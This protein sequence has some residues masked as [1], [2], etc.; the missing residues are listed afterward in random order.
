MSI[1]I[2]R[3][4]G[5]NYKSQIEASTGKGRP[6][7]DVAAL[8]SNLAKEF[9]C[10]QGGSPYPGVEINVQLPDSYLRKILNDPEAQ[11]N[12]R[13]EFRAFD[14]MTLIMMQECSSK[15]GVLKYHGIYFD[16]NGIIGMQAFSGSPP[17]ASTVGNSKEADK[18]V[19]HKKESGLTNVSEEDLSEKMHQRNLEQRNQIE[20]LRIYN[21]DKKLNEENKSTFKIDI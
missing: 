20:R 14:E 11:E 15:G 2:P 18:K 17:E 4:D 6:T 10:L 19:I 13:E 1:T 3:T 7:S 12:M 5:Y 8:R 16:S 9:K 21:A